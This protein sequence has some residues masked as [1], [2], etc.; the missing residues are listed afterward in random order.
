[1]GNERFRCFFFNQK[2]VLQGRR[3]AHLVEWAPYVGWVLCNC[4]GSIVIGGPLLRVIPPVSSNISCQS[5]AVK[6]ISKFF[7]TVWRHLTLAWC[8]IV[9]CRLL[10]STGRFESA[11]IHISAVKPP[12]LWVADWQRSLE[13][14]SRSANQLADCFYWPDFTFYSWCVFRSWAPPSVKHD[15]ETI[16]AAC[17]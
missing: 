8:R 15:T 16:E 10:R 12:D 4:L 7:N 1:M 17:P 6:E 3:R 9:W 13:Q 5:I 14:S 2:K 11:L